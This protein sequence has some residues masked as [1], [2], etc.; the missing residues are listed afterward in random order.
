M[1]SFTI[2]T[3]AAEEGLDRV[4][5]RQPLVLDPGDWTAWLDPGVTDHDT[6]AALLEPRPPGRFEAY[7]VRSAVNATRNN[8]PD[9]LAPAPPAELQGVIDPV[10]GEVLGG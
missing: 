8:G 5:D 6:V 9:L 10:T 3:T 7:P 4:H 1:V 2:I